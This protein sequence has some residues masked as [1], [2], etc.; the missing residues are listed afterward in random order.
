MRGGII[1]TMNTTTPDPLAVEEAKLAVHAAAL[2]LRDVKNRLTDA[3]RHVRNSGGP[4]VL[5]ANIELVA[6]D[7][8]TLESIAWNHV[9][10]EL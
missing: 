4:A 9:G 2:E 10:T 5:A 6:R 8:A 7:L 3:V 1:S